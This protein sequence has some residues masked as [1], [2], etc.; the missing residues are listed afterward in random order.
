MS[1]LVIGPLDPIHSCKNHNAKHL[2]H[3]NK[4]VLFP[5][6]YLRRGKKMASREIRFLRDNRLG[7]YPTEIGGICVIVQSQP[8]S[9][10]GQNV[11][12]FPSCY[13]R[14]SG[15][16]RNEEKNNDNRGEMTFDVITACFAAT[17]TERACGSVAK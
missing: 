16:A 17:R 4:N 5:Y 11:V 8:A 13:C 6:Y 9:E 14:S 1:T 7:V 12:F 2:F 3:F 10:N 15:R